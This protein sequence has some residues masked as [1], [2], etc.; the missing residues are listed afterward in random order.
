MSAS[1]RLDGKPGAGLG[2]SVASAGD[3]NGDG[4]EDVVVGAPRWRGR[5]EAFVVFGR[6]AGAVD[7]GRL[8]SRGV[9]IVGTGF[10]REGAAGT[11]V[12]GAGDVN[13]DGLADVVVTDPWALAV[14]RSRG[15][16]QDIREGIAYVVYGRR[17]A[18]TV[19]LERL[20]GDGFAI[21]GVDDAP[22]AG[23]GD[24][25]GDGFDDVVVA[26]GE[27]RDGGAHVVFG[28][29]R[30]RSLDAARLGARGFAIRGAPGD[31]ESE[32]VA[33]AGDVNGDG[34]ADVVLGFPV[35]LGAPPPRG[36]REPFGGGAAYVVFGRRST[37][38]V[39]LGRLAGGGFR[40][41]PPPGRIGLVGAAVAG[42]GDVNGDGLGDVIVGAPALPLDFRRRRL[43]PGSAFVVFGART[44]QD[45]TL[46][47]TRGFEIRGALPPRYTGA[48]VAGAG[49]RNGD[50]LTD[51]LVGAPGDP[52]DG[53]RP[54]AAYVVYGRAA[55]APVELATLGPADGLVLE[56]LPGDGAGSA[57]AAAS[58][59]L[60]IGA[61]Q[62]CPAAKPDGPHVFDEPAGTVYVVGDAPGPMTGDRDLLAGTAAADV[63]SGE[64]GDDCLYGRAGADRLDGGSGADSVLASGGDDTLRGG[65]GNDVLGAGAGDDRAAGGGGRDRLDG[66]AGADRLDGGAGADWFDGAGGDDR[67][68]GG[69]GRDDLNGEAGADRVFGGV[70]RDAVYGGPGADLADGGRGDDY[71]A[72]DTEADD[73]RGGPGHDRLFGSRGADRLDGGAGD[74]TL[75]GGLGP[76]RLR[77]GAGDDAID[78]RDGRREQV[79]CGAGTDRVEAD[80]G[81]RVAGCERVVRSAGR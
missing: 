35:S 26:S 48:A 59:E 47:D 5:G 79:R 17:L 51:L 11:S 81:D 70:G 10:S 13:G 54:G 76:D 3:F 18:G 58:G 24:V 39:R 37:A 30:R 38:A 57:V 8:G 32:S 9:R 27:S 50:G 53:A 22:A 56:G 43:G 80:R 25:N 34:L 60:L 75:Q 78:A 28:A 31:L 71:L 69:I 16:V 15:R 44:P 2:A 46:G 77:G 4:I 68:H 63:L 74:D 66:S 40:I 33:G 49:D 12:A 67:L 6:P 41:S 64:A 73:L 45:V 52:E 55:T 62:S 29:A 7:A 14:K 36:A 23:A 1:G 21:N 72:G 42:A 61:P 20:R 19:H 65:A